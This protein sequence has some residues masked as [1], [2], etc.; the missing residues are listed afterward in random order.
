M[1]QIPCET[2]RSVAGTRG[3]TVNPET[4]TRILLQ[5]VR[6]NTL[7]A[8]TILGILI[9]FIFSVPTT[10]FYARLGTTPSEVGITYASIISGSTFGLL[11][12]VGL[13][14]AV[15][16]YLFLFLLFTGAYISGIRLLLALAGDPELIRKN[17]LL[18]EEQQFQRKLER[19]KKAFRGTPEDWR[20]IENDLL[21]RKALSN[22]ERRTPEEE[23]ELRRYHD[24]RIYTRMIRSGLRRTRER[25]TPRSIK[26]IGIII[27]LLFAITVGILTL[28]A[29]IQS[30]QVEQGGRVFGTQIGIF[31][32]HAQMITLHPDSASNQQSL[33]SLIGPLAGPK[34]ITYLL[35]QNDQYLIVYSLAKNETILVPNSEATVS[36]AP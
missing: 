15:L 11:L 22:K 28:L 8:L 36:S 25:F 29:R 5:W 23:N 3:S 30:E 12:I 1:E 9:Y 21:R 16:Y 26:A 18:D 7:A 24:L 14:I 19:L 35:G 34:A 13:S 32:Y 20:G 6:D 10:Y 27:F 31:D 2:C 17:R 4:P 33:Q